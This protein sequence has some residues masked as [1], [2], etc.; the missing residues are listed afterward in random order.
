MKSALESKMRVYQLNDINPLELAPGILRAADQGD[1]FY[2][3]YWDQAFQLNC[4]LPM[5]DLTATTARIR[6]KL[7]SQGIYVWEDGIPVSQAAVGRKT[8]RGAVINAVYTPPHYRGKGYATA[9]VASLSQMLLDS[10]YDFCCLFADLDNPISNKLYL[11]IGY[12]PV[13]DFAEYTFADACR[14]R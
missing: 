8:I 9:C 4:G 12:Q 7:K 6:Q 2:L 13:C 5:S 1:L 3:P 14:V 11:N 10:K